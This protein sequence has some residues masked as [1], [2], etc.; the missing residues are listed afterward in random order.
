MLGYYLTGAYTV[1]TTNTGEIIMPHTRA[2]PSEFTEKSLQVL[3]RSQYEGLTPLGAK[4][5]DLRVN[6]ALTT[7][8]AIKETGIG[9]TEAMVMDTRVIPYRMELIRRQRPAIERADLVRGLQAAVEIAVDDRDSGAI[10]KATMALAKIAGMDKPASEMA[11]L[12]TKG[13]AEDIF[14]GLLSR[15]ASGELPVDEA[16]KLSQ[17]TKVASDVQNNEALTQAF[18]SPQEKMRLQA[19]SRAHVDNVIN[20]PRFLKLVA[21]Q[22]QDD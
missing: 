17:Q 8:Q 10:V 1:D 9:A 3:V 16:L 20:S 12:N 22:Q 13:T 7:E 19:E 14:R 4:Y 15:A 5:N 6:N 2:H 11:T 18:I 21:S